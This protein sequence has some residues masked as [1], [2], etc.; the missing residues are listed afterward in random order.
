MNALGDLMGFV[1]LPSTPALVIDRSAAVL[2]QMI[3]EDGS[4]EEIAVTIK[5]AFKFID[6]KAT[7]H[8]YFLLLPDEQSLQAIF[9]ALHLA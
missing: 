2:A 9:K 3:G 7:L 1:V 8:G 4:A 5:T 6:K